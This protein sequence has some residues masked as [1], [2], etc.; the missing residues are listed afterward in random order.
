MNKGVLILAALA[1]FLGGCGNDEAPKM[2]QAGTDKGMQESPA[3][4][5]EKPQ[6]SEP[7]SEAAPASEGMSAAE[8]SMMAPTEAPMAAAEPMPAPSA[9][10]PAGMT[11]GEPA[12]GMTMAEAPADKGK[13]IYDS[14]CFACHAMALAGAPKFGDKAAWAP[15]IAQGMDTLV[16]HAINGFQGKSGVMPPKGG[17]TDLSDEDISAA[18]SYMVDNAK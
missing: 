6:P 4:T 7:M 12:A 1:V 5:M 14:V 8:G 15:R 10:A 16:S 3:T 17:R 18:V 2:K 13:Q 9:E 11:E